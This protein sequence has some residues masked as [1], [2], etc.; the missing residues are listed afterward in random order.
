[1]INSADPRHGVNAKGAKSNLRRLARFA[2][3]RDL[4]GKK[5]STTKGTKEHEGRAWTTAAKAGVWNFARISEQSA[6]RRRA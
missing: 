3:F 2:P 1:M 5:E 6:K 4:R